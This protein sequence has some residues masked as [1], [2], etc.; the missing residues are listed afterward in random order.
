[1]KP[2]SRKCSRSLCMFSDVRMLPRQTLDEHAYANAYRFFQKMGDPVRDAYV[3]DLPTSK[4]PQTADDGS[5]V[6][7]AKRDVKRSDHEIDDLAEPQQH[8]NSLYIP[9]IFTRS[10]FVENSL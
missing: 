5:T 8:R 1:M 4:I 6:A 7:T 2:Y 10:Q 9:M 3:Q